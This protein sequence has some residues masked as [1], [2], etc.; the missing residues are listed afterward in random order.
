MKGSSQGQVIA[1]I[2]KKLPTRLS[3]EVGK[4]VVSYSNLEY[5][6][7]A[8]V[9]TILQLQ[10][11]EARLALS[12]PPVFESLDVVQDLLALRALY[13]EFDF[14]SFRVRLVT[15]NT[16]RNNIS[17]GIWLRHPDTK[18]IFLRLTKGQWDKQ[19]SFAPPVRRIVFPQSI[20]MGHKECAKVTAMIADAIKG[21]TRL[22][23]LVDAM[24]KASPDRFR[25]RSP[26]VDPL[27]R[28]IPPKPRGLRVASAER[29][30]TKMK[31]E[32]LIAAALAKKDVK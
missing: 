27:A 28:R 18:E 3:A 21:A 22:G 8:I 24:R 6:F 1:R 31:R 32:A 14:V 29:P 16:L 2:L 23:A 9:A 17:H 19:Q 20:P 25:E 11:P 12:Q 15:I 10:K 5:Q 30:S 4:V 26:L 13:A 7:Q